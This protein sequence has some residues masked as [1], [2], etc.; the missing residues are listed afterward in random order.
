LSASYE[1]VLA[2]AKLAPPRMRS[3]TIE[4]PRV[5]WALDADAAASTLVAALAGYGKTTAVRAWCAARKVPV[6]W[7]TLDASDND[8]ARLWRYVI[9]AVRQPL[10]PERNCLSR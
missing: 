3:Q 5:T 2:E 10:Q 6:A 8:P 1:V 9:T 7:V 4:R